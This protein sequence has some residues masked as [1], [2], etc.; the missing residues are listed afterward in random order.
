MSTRQAMRRA[1]GGWGPIEDKGGNKPVPL[2]NDK[3]DDTQIEADKP[4]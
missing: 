4:Q 3:P 1:P 2:T